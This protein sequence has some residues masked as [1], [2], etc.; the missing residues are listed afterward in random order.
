VVAANG[1]SDYHYV[2]DR[3][4]SVVQRAVRFLQSREELGPVFVSDRYG[5]LPGTLPLS[6]VHLQGS[7][8][9][10]PDVV[11]S[12][13]FDENAVVSGMPGTEYVGVSRESNRGTHGSFSPRDV[14]NTFI[15]SGPSFRSRFKDELPSANVDVAPT[16]AQLLGV[17]LSTAQGRVLSESLVGGPE[18]SAFRV[19]ETIEKPKTP[20][21]GLATGAGTFTFELHETSLDLGSSHWRYLDS[22][23]EIRR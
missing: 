12:Y 19:A 2:P 4:K 7:A 21:R 22:A 13:H 15:A 10:N 8:D 16:L 17:T 1:G 5:D 11:V 3:D 20:A 14:H 18:E 6:S 9:R 23:K